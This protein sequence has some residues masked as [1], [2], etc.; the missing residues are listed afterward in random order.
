MS[1]QR[2]GFS[3]HIGFIF[4]I[5]GSAIGLGNIWRFPYLA[6][7]NGGGAFLFVYIVFTFLFGMVLMMTEIAIGRRTGKSAIEAFAHLTERYAFIGKVAAFI[8]VLIIPFYCVIGGWVL[9]Y[10]FSSGM[11][12]LG[13]MA[14]ADYFTDFLATGPGDIPGSPLPWFVLFACLTFLLPA[15]GVRKGIEHVSKIMM[16]CLLIIIIGL[17][18]YMLLFAGAGDA[19]V[20]FLTPE[21]GNLTLDTVVTAASQVFFSM[22][23]AMGI[24][25][26]YGS[27]MRKDT[28]I[29]RSTFQVTA[30][31]LAVS[32]LAGLLVIPAVT[33]YAEGE[34]VQG[35]GLMFEVLP[36]AFSNMPGGQAIAVVFF[37]LVFLAAITSSVSVAETL[38]CQSTDHFG[39]PRRMAVA[40]ILSF[41]LAAG[42]FV[43]FDHSVFG[44]L[45]FGD[46][47][48]LEIFDFISSSLLVPLVAI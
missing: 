17:V 31:S 3:S 10:I 47:H 19:M 26:T 16:P 6:S 39:T 41:T 29:K 12:E 24:T 34:P 25:I 35:P 8:P 14:D 46:A 5:A 9:K 11:G 45:S 48:L 37:I 27:Y 40:V 36:A 13:S 33:I 1:E 43:C 18:L 20:S 23:L 38:I 44:A 22:S 28:D 4:A 2:D 42:T 15:L 30:A 7:T 32:V 21:I